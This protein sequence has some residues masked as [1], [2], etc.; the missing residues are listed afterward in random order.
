M[1]AAGHLL[2]EAADLGGRLEEAAGLQGTLAGLEGILDLGGRLE[3]AAGLGGTL[4]GAGLGLGGTLE[5]AAGQ[6]LDKAALVA[7]QETL[8][9]AAVAAAV[10]LYYEE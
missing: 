4:E 10:R 1:G 6:G 8:Q 5:G 3:R 9:T 7:L 2:V